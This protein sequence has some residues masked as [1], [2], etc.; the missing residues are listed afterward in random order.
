MDDHFLRRQQERKH[1]ER[2]KRAKR[3]N[4]II[5]DKLRK[6]NMADKF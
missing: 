5:Y 1:Q 6:N 2:I 4:M 3:K